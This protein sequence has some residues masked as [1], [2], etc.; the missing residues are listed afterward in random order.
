M[1]DSN[2]SNHRVSLNPDDAVAAGMTLEEALRVYPD[3]DGESHV[4]SINPCYYLIPQLSQSL[5]LATHYP[6]GKII[7][8][9]L[10][11]GL[12]NLQDK[13]SEP[14]TIIQNTRQDILLHGGDWR[15]KE[16]A[17]NKLKADFHTSKMVRWSIRTLEEPMTRCDRLATNTGVLSHHMRQ[18]AI[19]GGLIHS[20]LITGKDQQKMVEVLRWWKGVLLEKANAAQG[21][22]RDRVRRVMDHTPWKEDPWGEIL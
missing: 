17:H 1:T 16:F 3:G 5:S 13:L 4:Y 19:I 21:I 9:A 14:L 7:A 6:L 12:A 18:L 11:L 15:E 2:G 22:Q 20:T 10:D 8:C